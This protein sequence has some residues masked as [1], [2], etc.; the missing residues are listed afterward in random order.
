MTKKKLIPKQQYVAGQSTTINN[1][2]QRKLV[3]VDSDISFKRKN[4]QIGWK[5]QFNYSPE[6]QTI[7]DWADQYIGNIGYSSEG[8]KNF[9]KG[10]ID[11]SGFVQQ[12]YKHYGLETPNYS[13]SLGKFGTSIGKDLNQAK[14]GQLLYFV[15][16]PDPS[17]PS[18]TSGGHVGIYLGKD[19]NGGYYMLH[20]GSST[21]GVAIKKLEQSDLGSLKDIRDF[22]ISLHKYGGRL[23]P[24]KRYI[25]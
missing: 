23:I 9:D 21:K 2:N 12:F 24:K 3:D 4:P 11:C 8:F 18:G 22:G 16:K 17:T 6:A 15:H 14:A 5:Y 19:G 13:H 1:S 25:K 10:K 7:I 20:S